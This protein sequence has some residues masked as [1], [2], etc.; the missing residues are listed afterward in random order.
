MARRGGGGTGI[1]YEGSLAVATNVPG[2][3]IFIDNRYSGTTPLT[4]AGL[5]KG[6]HEVKLRKT[7]YR[8]EVR[9]VNIIAGRTTKLDV[10][11]RATTS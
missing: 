6:S 7:G 1:V 11:I 10:T 8:E 4:I 3:T 9:T 2:V 5:S